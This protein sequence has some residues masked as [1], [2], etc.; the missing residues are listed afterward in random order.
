LLIEAFVIDI[1]RE[2][3]DGKYLSITMPCIGCNPLFTAVSG[4][5]DKSFFMPDRLQN[6][7]L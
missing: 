4:M 6:N 2:G 3:I 5:Q 1:L 7:A